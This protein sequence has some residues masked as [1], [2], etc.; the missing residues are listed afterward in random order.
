MAL[1]Y[2]YNKNSLIN[3]EKTLGRKFTGLVKLNWEAPI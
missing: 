1:I 3:V 2:I